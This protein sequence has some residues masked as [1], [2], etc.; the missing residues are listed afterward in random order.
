M[1][2]PTRTVVIEAGLSDELLGVCD[3]NIRAVRERL[4]V[5]ISARGGSITV[6]GETGAVAHAAR[7]IRQFIARVQNGEP[8]TDNAVASLIALDAAGGDGSLDGLDIHP[9]TPGQARYLAAIDAHDMVFVTGPAGTGK[10]FLAVAGAVDALKANRVK[11]IVLV[12]PAVEAGEKLGF[13]PGDLREKVNPYL[14]P[15]YDALHEMLGFETTAAYLEQGIIEVAPIAFMRGRTLHRAFIIMDEGQNTSPA[16]MLM[17]LTRMG[18]GAKVVVTGDVTQ[19]DLPP[20]MP[21]GLLRALEVLRGVGGIGF[22]ALDPA[23]IVRHALV[24]EIVR[25]FRVDG[26][27]RR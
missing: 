18:V 9:R 23:D 12:R 21:S 24:R 1:A 14:I 10:T 15:V 26:E 13:L 11:K 2:K 4:G 5:G 6:K 16:Q 19:I 27:R 22:V 20:G 8:I 25:V 17:F 3:A 7:V